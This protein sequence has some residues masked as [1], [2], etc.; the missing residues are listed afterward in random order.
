MVIFFSP[1]RYFSI[2]LY[3][4]GDIFGGSTLILFY[5]FS[6]LTFSSIVMITFYIPPKRLNLKCNRLCDGKIVLFTKKESIFAA[7]FLYSSIK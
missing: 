3:D 6:S 7:Y 5:D 1:V 2:F 4:N